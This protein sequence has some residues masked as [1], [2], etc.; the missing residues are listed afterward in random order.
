MISKFNFFKMV[1]YLMKTLMLWK[2]Q[3][4]PESQTIISIAGS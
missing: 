2:V 3:L 4:K 1:N